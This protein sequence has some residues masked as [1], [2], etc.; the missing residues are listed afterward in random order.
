MHVAVLLVLNIRQ[1]ELTHLGL[2]VD[3]GSTTGR[4]SYCYLLVDVYLVKK[5]SEKLKSM[6]IYF[7][8]RLWRLLDLQTKI[9]L[10][11]R[12]CNRQESALGKRIII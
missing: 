9:F 10:Q 12:V 5:K 1:R 11:C 7:Q 2:M 8:G 6:R 4:L 3:E